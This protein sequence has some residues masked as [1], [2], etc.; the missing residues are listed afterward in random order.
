[1]LKKFWAV[2]LTAALA[3]CS[4]C[5]FAGSMTTDI[6]TSNI[7]LTRYQNERNAFVTELIVEGPAPQYYDEEAPPEGVLE[8][9]YPSGD[10]ELKAWVSDDPGDG[11]RHPAV[12]YAHGGF[13]FGLSDWED[14]QAF[15]DAGFVLMTPMVRGENGN[16]GNYEGFLGEV[17]DVIAAG[18][19]LKELPY[20][21]PENI[22][23]CGHSVGGTLS[24]LSS[25]LPS[26]YKAI[27]TFGASPN[28]LWFFEGQP[29]IAPFDISN[30]AET[31]IRSP[32]AYV[33]CI[34]KPL[35]V[36]VGKEDRA[37]YDVSHQL[38]DFAKAYGK[39]FE[40]KIIE[41]THGTS[42][43]PSILECIERFSDQM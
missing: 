13:A 8:V 26:S 1:M 25:M 12:V 36:F 7:D 43:Y 9:I 28:Q 38:A 18:D 42:L 39:D 3:F 10:L 20:V 37:Y 30:P 23:L 6:D 5:S 34:Q 2:L 40:L 29:E 14:A 19:Y 22:F 24:M 31:V 17:D 35:Y 21:D 27:G 4:A 15:A 11:Q 16:P 33:E 41:G 32:L